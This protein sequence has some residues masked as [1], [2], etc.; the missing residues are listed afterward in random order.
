MFA[1]AL[2]MACVAKDDVAARLLLEQLGADPAY[3]NAT[4]M[5]A[6]MCAARLS[7]DSKMDVAV[8]EELMRRSLAI[9]ELLLAR[10]VPLNITELS[11]G[12]SALHFAVM[13]NNH[14][15]VK[16]FLA[17]KSMLYSCYCVA[18]AVVI[19]ERMPSLVFLFSSWDASRRLLQE[20]GRA[21]GSGARQAR[22]RAP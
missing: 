12:N 2:M 11:A 17:G 16:R 10:S 19:S 5:N 20:Q 15:V 13:S 8:Q 21:D 4:S 14:A 18:V 22:E 3:G 6:L 7:V 9:V 1:V